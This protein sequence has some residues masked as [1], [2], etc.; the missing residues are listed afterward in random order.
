LKKTVIIQLWQ[1]STQA[2]QLAATPFFFAAAAAAMDMDVEIHALGASVEL[3]IQ[4]NP[5]R[6]Q[7]IPPMNRRLSDFIDD[8]IRAG[9]KIHACSTAMRDRQLVKEDMIAEFGEIIGMVTM[10][11]RATGDGVTVMTF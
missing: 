8:A 3:F 2:P 1:A 4:D 7:T 10:L 5:A 9:A 11:D 6:H